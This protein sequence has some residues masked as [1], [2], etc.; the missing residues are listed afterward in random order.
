[1]TNPWVAAR[2]EM[3]STRK[4]IRRNYFRL[5]TILG[6]IPWIQGDEEVSST[7]LGTETER[8]FLGVRQI[9]IEA[10]FHFLGP[11]SNQV[12]DSSD[13]VWANTKAHQNFLVLIQDLFRHE[14]NEVV[15]ICPPV[16]DICAS[17]SPANKRFSEARDPGHQ[18]ARI[19]DHT[20]LAALSFLRQR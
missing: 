10:D 7:V 13:P 12:D 16:E 15:F 5:K 8:I 19:N 2:A 20:R 6:E 9:S 11:F 18:H 4:G 1:V 3:R 14:P 17:V